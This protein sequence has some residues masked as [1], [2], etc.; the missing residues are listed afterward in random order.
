MLDT[1][2][3]GVLFFKLRVVIPK[4]A[5][6][7]ATVISDVGVGRPREMIRVQTVAVGLIVLAIPGV[8]D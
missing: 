3:W 6:K 8:V 4:K 7:E 1:S 5:A 2:T